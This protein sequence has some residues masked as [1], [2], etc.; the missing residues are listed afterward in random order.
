MRPKLIF[1]VKIGLAAVALLVV[2]LGLLGIHFL[3]A[4]R[5]VVE[6]PGGP[7]SLYENNTC[8]RLVITGKVVGAGWEAQSPKTLEFTDAEIDMSS[9]ASMPSELEKKLAK[10]AKLTISELQI[11]LVRPITASSLA[12][13]EKFVIAKKVKPGKVLLKECKASQVSKQLLTFVA[14]VPTL[15]LNQVSYDAPLF[16]D[17]A[18][19]ASASLKTLIVVGLVDYHAGQEGVLNRFNVNALVLGEISESSQLLAFASENKFVKLAQVSVRHCVID[20]VELVSDLAPLSGLKKVALN[21]TTILQSC[22]LSVLD[23]ADL[24]ELSI[25]DC[26]LPANDKQLFTSLTKLP[27]SMTLDESV[28][29]L[30]QPDKFVVSPNKHIIEVHTPSLQPNPE[31]IAFTLHAAKDNERR[32]DIV[33]SYFVKTESPIVFESW[34][35]PFTNVTNLGMIVYQNNQAM[36][37]EDTDKIVNMLNK[38]AQSYNKCPVHKFILINLCN[39]YVEMAKENVT[40]QA[41]KR[42]FSKVDEYALSNVNMPENAPF[43]GYKADN[44]LIPATFGGVIAKFGP[45]STSSSATTTADGWRYKQIKHKA[46]LD[47]L[48]KELDTL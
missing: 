3:L 33:V 9:M 4:D 27:K 30:L 32:L 31:T 13:L 20:K 23:G 17:L 25:I 38:I 28:Y 45:S 1:W 40:S 36:F 8:V 41:I 44:D 11:D 47:L 22:N 42:L 37:F 18:K 24:E 29:L 43:N 21:N 15:E 48:L 19:T 46:S 26:H 35:L 10:L 5:Q 7:V 6:V 39:S 16:Q 12:A 34:Q 14:S 2:I